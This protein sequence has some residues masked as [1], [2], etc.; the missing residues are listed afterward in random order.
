M[1]PDKTTTDPCV[2]LWATPSLLYLDLINL[3]I[4]LNLPRNLSR[5][6]IKSMTDAQFTALK[7]KDLGKL[8]RKSVR[9]AMSALTDAG[10]AVCYTPGNHDVG[11]LVAIVVGG[12]D[13]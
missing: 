11:V 7:A 9:D 6:R 12:G 5:N 2:A 3:S 8:Q 13:M 1:P 4:T 10:I